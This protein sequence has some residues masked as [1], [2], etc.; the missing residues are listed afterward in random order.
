MRADVGPRCLACGGSK[1]RVLHRLAA[2]RMLVCR[3]CSLVFVDPIPELGE[4][5]AYADEAHRGIG[6]AETSE[7]FA[8]P[9]LDDPDDPLTASYAA[10]VDLL[11]TA[12]EGRRLLDVGC[13]NGSFAAFASARGW[14][15]VVIDSSPAACE[16]ARSTYGLEALTTAFP[17]SS[18]DPGLE[19]RSFDAVTFLDFLEHVPDPRAAVKRARELL[20]PGGVLLVNSPNHASV[21]C[22]AIDAL[23][24]LP[25][26]PIRRRLEQYYH[27]SHVSVF[28]PRSLRRLVR[29]TGLEVLESGQN[30]PVLERFELPPPMV[31][32]L[33]ALATVGRWAG[34]QSRC[35]VLA[36][37]SMSD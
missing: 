27:P 3:D 20:A 26:P 31:A 9:D 28:N 23:G 10:T 1:H 6:M 24:R 17:E 22:L 36:C 13:G 30:S 4:L 37:R 25:F 5:V 16:H 21:L 7:Y 14:Q 32:G 29:D 12:C 11:A 33:R 2:H 34:R 8:P 35:W 19:A 18:R 15:P